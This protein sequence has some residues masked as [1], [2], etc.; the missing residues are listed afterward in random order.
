MVMVM[1]MV[2]LARPKE[3]SCTGWVRVRARV[4]KV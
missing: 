2:T 3:Y 4:G 1:V